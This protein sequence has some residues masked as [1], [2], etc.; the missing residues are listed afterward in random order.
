M[1]ECTQTQ[2]LALLKSGEVVACATEYSYALCAD[3]RSASACQKVLDLKQR[4]ETLPIAVAGYGNL[5]GTVLEV[6]VVVYDLMHAFWPGPLTLIM[7]SCFGLPAAIVS[8]DQSV[9]VRVP[10]WEPLLALCEQLDAPITV[11][12]AN[13]HGKP[14][15]FTQKTLEQYFPDIPWFSFN[16]QPNP[17]PSTMADVREGY[18]RVIRSGMI[19]L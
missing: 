14:P 18:P 1:T 7:K 9:A 6:P 11:T 16:P 15:A 10:G 12:S 4:T 2:A 17:K 3:A 13:P 19:E 8:S 5:A